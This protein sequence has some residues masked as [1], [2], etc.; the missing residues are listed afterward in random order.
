MPDLNHVLVYLSYLRSD[1]VELIGN[2]DWCGV[3]YGVDFNYSGTH[4]RSCVA[5][6]IRYVGH[7]GIEDV[8]VRLS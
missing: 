3:L 5:R 1:L 6:F 7:R 2:S 8:V 4:P